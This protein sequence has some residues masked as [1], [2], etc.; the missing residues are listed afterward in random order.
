MLSRNKINIYDFIDYRKF[1]QAFYDLE[2]TLDPTFS[3]RVF[4]AAVDI[5]ASLLVK[6]LQGKRHISSKSVDTLIDFFKFK[7]G[8]AEYFRELV[9]YAKAKSDNETK[10]HFEAL[11]K[12]RPLSCREIEESHYQ[13]FSTWY[14]PMIRSALDVYAYHGKADGEALGKH[15]IPKLTGNEVN[16]AVEA[17]LQ[18]GFVKANDSGR[19]VPSEVHVKTKEK[20]YN[21]SISNYQKS[22]TDLAINA[23]ENT[24]KENRDVSTLT[25]ALD[26]SQIEKIKKILQDARKS[27]V[28]VVNQ[29]PSSQCDSVYQLNL[30]LFPMM[31]K[32]N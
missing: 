19:I 27:I 4:A 25:M 14:Y 29:M 22:I 31:K 32:D 15:C 17:L 3:Y 30:Q 18:L 8:K 24:P 11:Q 5:D 23:L 28:K 6:I 12:M 2:K 10:T 13:Y 21:A 9:L 1:L 26:S 20:W 7:E 16:T